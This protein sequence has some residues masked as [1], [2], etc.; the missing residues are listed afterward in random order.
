[1]RS[2]QAG[3][4]LMNSGIGYCMVSMADFAACVWRRHIGRNGP[5]ME[6][7]DGGAIA[8]IGDTITGD[9][10]SMVTTSERIPDDARVSDECAD[11]PQ[12]PVYGEGCRD[13]RCS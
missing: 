8:L 4:G 9:I 1:M 6:H 10:D 13:S 12:L 7:D 2:I 3:K 11:D 5:Y